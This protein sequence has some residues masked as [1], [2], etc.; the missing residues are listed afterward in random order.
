[1]TNEYDAI[2]VQGDETELRQLFSNLLDN[3]LRH[4][5][6]NGIVRIASGGRTG[7]RG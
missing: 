4:G 1:M 6:P 5:P 3:A 7:F 2:C